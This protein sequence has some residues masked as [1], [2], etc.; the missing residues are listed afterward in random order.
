MSE[1]F[2]NTSSTGNTS[3]P[4]NTSSSDN[5]LFWSISAAAVTGVFCIACA[6]GPVLFST[7][8]FCGVAYSTLQPPDYSSQNFE[9]LNR[10]G[11]TNKQAYAK[12]HPLSSFCRKLF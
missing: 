6:V 5:V 9:E 1:I 3:N 4:D 12:L 2:D 7:G 11:Y 8:V 10:I